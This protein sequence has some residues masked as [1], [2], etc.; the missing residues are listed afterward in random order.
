METKLLLLFNLIILL[1]TVIVADRIFSK[2]KSI[3][4]IAE[5]ID[6]LLEHVARR[7]RRSSS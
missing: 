2:T 6:S 3:Q 4:K 5:E 1:A 7:I